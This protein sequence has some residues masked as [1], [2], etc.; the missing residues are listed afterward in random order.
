MLP[1]AKTGSESMI[2]LDSSVIFSIQ[3]RDANTRIAIGLVQSASEP[4]ILTQ[5]CEVE[6]I[7]ALCRREFQKQITHAQAQDSINDLELNLRNGVYRLLPFPESVFSRARTISRSITPILGVRAADVLHVAAAIELGA[8]AL[9]TF[10][11]RQHRTAKEVGL[12][13]NPLA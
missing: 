4:L 1:I 9:Y 12:K 7:N 10:D 6:F 11:Q 8:N 13:V 2:Y 3:A 5:L